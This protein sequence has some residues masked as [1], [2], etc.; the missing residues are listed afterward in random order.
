MSAIRGAHSASEYYRPQG[1]EAQRRLAA[2]PMADDHFLSPF[3]EP[4]SL[5]LTPFPF[6]PKVI[7][8]PV[9]SFCSLWVSDLHTLS[10]TDPLCRL[11][12]HLPDA[13]NYKALELTFLKASNTLFSK[14]F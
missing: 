5:S 11:N 4:V 8:L 6:I 14:D 9:W 2:F 1:T 13:C 7:T 3:A 12:L 10:I